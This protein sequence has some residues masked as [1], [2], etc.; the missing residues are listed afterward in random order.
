MND[1]TARL[2]LEVTERLQ[3]SIRQ[4][5]LPA[6][7]ALDGQPRAVLSDYLRDEAAATAFE[8]RGP[9]GRAGQPTVPARC[10]G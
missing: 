8:L 6:I 10:A 4:G 9:P 7:V 3:R 5:D 2:L 1:D